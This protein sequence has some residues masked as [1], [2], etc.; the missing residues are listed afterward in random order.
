[1]KTIK[2]YK[3]VAFFLAMTMVLS[4]VKDDDYDVPNTDPVAP[5][6][7]GEIIS[8]NALNSLLEQEQNTNGN[9]ILSFTESNL[10][11]SGYVISNDEAGNIYEELVLQDSPSNPTRGVKVLI[12]VSPLNTTYEFGRKVYVKLDGLAV[13]YNGGVLSLGFRDGTQVEAIAESLM[14]QT[15]IREVELATIEAM[16]INISD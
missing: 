1:M 14:D 4:C 2:N 11:I 6:I 9:D 5:I 15:I 7:D 10:F 13:G 8:I 3:I 12:N 16:P